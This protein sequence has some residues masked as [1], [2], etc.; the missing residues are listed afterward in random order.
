MA[1]GR[2]APELPDPADSAKTIAAMLSKFLYEVL[3]MVFRPKTFATVPFAIMK[4]AEAKRR[5]TDPSQSEV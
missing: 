4:P 3:A 1:P 2:S 5:M